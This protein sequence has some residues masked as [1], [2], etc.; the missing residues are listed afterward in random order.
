[1]KIDASFQAVSQ[2]EN[3]RSKNIMWPMAALTSVADGAGEIE[4]P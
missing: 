2:P 1:M 4:A 3:K